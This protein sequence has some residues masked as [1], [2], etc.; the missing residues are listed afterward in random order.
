VERSLTA[1]VAY[2]AAENLI[3]AYGYDRDDSQSA[4]GGTLFAS[5]ILQPVIDVA[6][7]GKSA[8][9]RARLLNLGGTS[10][11]AG[12]WSAGTFEGQ[13]VSK[14]GVWKF[15]TLRSP[16]TWSAPYPGGWAQIR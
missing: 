15:E 6:P 1:A 5:Q 12:Y 9:V 7:D 14:D 11:G 2:D 3:G 10:G 13:I 16:S 8:K 4:E